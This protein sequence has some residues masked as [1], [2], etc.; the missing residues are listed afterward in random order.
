MDGGGV[1]TPRASVKEARQESK[2]QVCERQKSDMKPRE[3]GRSLQA[4]WVGS[5]RQRW[6]P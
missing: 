5:H 6:E 2:K 1:G 4:N 3:L